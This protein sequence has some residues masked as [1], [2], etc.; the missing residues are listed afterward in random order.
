[1]LSEARVVDVPEVRED[2]FAHLSATFEVKIHNY[3]PNFLGLHNMK[4]S[5]AADEGRLF[6]KCYHPK[7]YPLHEES[8]RRDIERSLSFQ[9]YLHEHANLCPGVLSSNQQFIHQTEA[10]HYYVVMHHVDGQPLKAGHVSA[11][12][13]YQLGKSTGKMHQLLSTFPC[14]GAGWKPS[15][16]RMSEKWRMN[17]SAALEHP[18]SNDRVLKA[19]EQQGV[20]LS[21]LDLSMFDSL[22]QGWAHWD[23]WVDNILVGLN[24]KISVIDFDTVQYGYSEIDI[25]RILLSGVLQE[26]ELHLEAARAFVAGYREEHRL[27]SGILPL[28][29]KLLWCREAYWWLKGHIDDMSIPPRRFADEMIWLTDRWDELDERYGGL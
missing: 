19:L 3:V 5:I 28:A 22:E 7:R 26:G 24:D 16:S 25:A 12:H 14:H 15:L 11:A 18:N 20:I 21:A 2:V 6:V 9:N 17:L 4:W 27:A 29:F 23:Y 13:M 1:M 8:R 10:G